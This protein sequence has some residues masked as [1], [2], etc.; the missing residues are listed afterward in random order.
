MSRCAV[1]IALLAGG[2]AAAQELNRGVVEIADPG[3]FDRVLAMSDVH[4]M[5][6]AQRRLLRAA[7]LIDESL[8]WTGGKTLLIVDGDS[9]DKGPNSLE[10]IDLFLALANEAEAA[11]GKVIHL[12]GNH[13]AE[14]LANPENAKTSGEYGFSAELRAARLPLA[15]VTSADHP[16][17]RFLRSM[18]VAARVGKWLFCHSGFLPGESWPEL[19]TAVANRLNQKDYRKGYSDS[20]IT[21][22]LAS[23]WWSDAARREDLQRRLRRMGF[24]AVVFGHLSHA[25]GAAG[26]ARSRDGFFI[27]IDNGMSIHGGSHAGSIL[28]LPR[29]AASPPQVIDADGHLAPIPEAGAVP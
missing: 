25:L 15:E 27:K 2:V 14:F 11:G 3:R 10:V 4:G 13:E 29:D 19:K 16:R 21:G 26:C 23:N 6:R 17:G 9:I 24:A 28:V 8:H 7:G 18:P 5:S 22:I 12:L 20:L 1:V